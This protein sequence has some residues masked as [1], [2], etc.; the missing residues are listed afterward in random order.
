MNL[1]INEY[2]HFEQIFLEILSVHAP[3]KK[4]LLR[5]NHVPYMTKAL[6]KEI[7]KSSELESNI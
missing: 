5:A 1:Q 4:K 7:M 2:T 6:R 3:T